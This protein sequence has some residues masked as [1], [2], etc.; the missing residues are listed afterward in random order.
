MQK[1]RGEKL[2]NV[3]VKLNKY[4]LNKLNNNAYV[5]QLKNDRTKILNN[6]NV[7]SLLFFRTGAINL[8]LY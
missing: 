8:M 5:V 4:W 7:S 6:S 3:Y 1:K 2:G